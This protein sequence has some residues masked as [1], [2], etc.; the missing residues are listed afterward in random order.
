MYT[1]VWK[2]LPQKTGQQ[3][4]SMKGQIVTI[5]GFGS[6]MASVVGFPG[7]ADR[8]ESACQ[9]TFYPWVRK[10]PWR[11]AWHPTPVFLPGK[12]H[13][14]RS[15][16]GCSPWGLK[17]STAEWLTLSLATVATIQL[18]VT[19]WIYRPWKSSGQNTGVGS[20]SLSR[21]SFQPRDWTQVSRIASGFFISWATR[22]TTRK[23]PQ[24]IYEWMNA[25]L[26]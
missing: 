9:C 8:K 16:V 19:P 3:T 12:S 2:P 7:G 21:G 23:Q 17:E 14:H 24:T 5:L 15:L 1:E 4:I 13:E 18:F 26:F 20:L 6:Q 25:I 22:E 10:V 11:R